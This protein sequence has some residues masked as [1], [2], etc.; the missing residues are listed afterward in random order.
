MVAEKAI[1]C[2]RYVIYYEAV[3]KPGNE[4]RCDMLQIL[5]KVEEKYFASDAT[6]AP[7]GWCVGVG[8]ATRLPSGHDV[9]KPWARRLPP[10][11]Y[12]RGLVRFSPQPGRPVSWLHDSTSSTA[13]LGCEPC[14]S[15]SKPTS[16]SQRS[17]D[18]EQQQVGRDTARGPLRIAGVEV[19]SS[20]RTST[21]IRNP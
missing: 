18:T 17:S 9:M 10:P 3:V 19:H 8:A 14:S 21:S 13:H 5:D 7:G 2:G 12:D 16:R 1:V 6:V 15:P 20:T 11:P 4:S